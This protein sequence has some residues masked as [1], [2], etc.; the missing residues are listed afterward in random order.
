M[1]HQGSRNLHQLSDYG[2]F[3][4]VKSSEIA[5][6]TSQFLKYEYKRNTVSNTLKGII[7]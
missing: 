2:A 7:D 1:A 6:K 3:K 5:S 4:S